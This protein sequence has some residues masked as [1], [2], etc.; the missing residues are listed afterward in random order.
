MRSEQFVASRRFLIEQGTPEKRKFRAIDDYRQGGALEKLALFDVNCMTAVATYAAKV[1]DPAG[2][3]VVA[4][5]SGEVLRDALH[6]DFKGGVSWMGRTLD[7]SKAYRQV[8]LATASLP[9]GVVMVNDPSD[10]R[11]KY[12]AAQSLPFGAT[13]SVFA[14]NRISRSL[15]HLGWHL[16]GLVAG[17][18]Y[19]DYPLLE[20]S[21]TANMASKSFELILDTLGWRFAKSDDKAEPFAKSFDL[22]GVGA[23]HV[24][25]DS[26]GEQTFTPGKDERQLPEVGPC[27][28]GFAA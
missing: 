8:P 6:S 3:V 22:L 1:S 13:S 20:P 7:L 23:A 9:F 16:A 15:L 2:D 28:Q 14:F 11:V 21:V 24:R 17:C 26:P 27:W 5:G 25:G 18:F 10:D 19:D 4:L 12:F